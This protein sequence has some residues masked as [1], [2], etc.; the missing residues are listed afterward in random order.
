MNSMTDIYELEMDG[1]NYDY[2]F[3]AMR[4]M[5]D[6]MNQDRFEL[7]HQIREA[8]DVA[9]RTRGQ[10]NEFAVDHLIELSEYSGFQDAAHSMAAV[11]MIAPFVESFFREAFREFDKKWQ[12]GDMVRNLL[13]S[14]PE[15]GLGKYMP[16]DLEVTLTA[17]FEYRNK[18]LHNG[19]EWPREVRESFDQRLEHSGWPVGWFS[20]ATIGDESRMFYMTDTFIEHCVGTIQNIAIGFEKLRRDR[21]RE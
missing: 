2:G 12:R 4:A 8:E 11:G 17:L 14:I 19:F 13:N 5:L 18:M 7:Q 16:E 3:H 1:L 10:H 21:M 20:R 9:R 15:M 6:R